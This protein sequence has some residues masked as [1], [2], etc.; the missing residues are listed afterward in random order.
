MPYT[1]VKTAPE[2]GGS[3]FDVQDWDGWAFG[4]AAGP[5]PE[6]PIF[7]LVWSGDVPLMDDPK[8]WDVVEVVEIEDDTFRYTEPSD[9]AII[10][11]MRVTT[12]L[13]GEI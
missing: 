7:V 8:N 10:A 13:D 1:R 11:G 12:V 2:A 4:T 6:E 3:E 9:I 5:S